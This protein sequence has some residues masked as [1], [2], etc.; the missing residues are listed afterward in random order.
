MKMQIINIEQGTQEWFQERMGIITASSMQK[1]LTNG[2]G[3]N[4]SLT[5]RSYMNQLLGEIMSGEPVEGFSNVYTERGHMLEP[6]ARNLYE[7]QTGFNVIETGFIKSNFNGYSLGYSPDGLI[8]DDGL[9][10]IKT[11]TAALQ[12]ETLR[13][14]EVPTEYIAQIQTGLLVTGR[15][16]LDYVSFCPCLPLFVKRLYPDKSY[17]E[18]ILE[19]CNEFYKELKLILIQLNE[20]ENV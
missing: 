19:K 17:Q 4:E 20:T 14:K 18:N 2:K 10:E 3:T 13:R 12:I 11:K 8:N 1:V 15:K 6:E 5:R 7:I 9:L 16:W